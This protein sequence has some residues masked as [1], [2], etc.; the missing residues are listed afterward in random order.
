VYGL[1]DCVCD[2]NMMYIFCC[3]AA[4]LDA[5]IG[6]ICSSFNTSGKLFLVCL[7]CLSVRWPL[8]AT[9]IAEQTTEVFY[10]CVLLYFAAD[11][12]KI[13]EFSR[14]FSHL[15]LGFVFVVLIVFMMMCSSVMVRGRL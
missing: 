7:H 3:F 12:F 13:F 10:E 2:Y 11:H 9:F 1:D 6:R 8:L 15:V 14:P 4:M 5:V